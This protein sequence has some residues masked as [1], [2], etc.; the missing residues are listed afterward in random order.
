[1]PRFPSSA[2]SGGTLPTEVN[3]LIASTLPKIAP[4]IADNVFNATPFLWFMRQKGRVK[5]WDGGESIE[6]P[7][8]YDKN[9]YARAYTNYEVMD[10]GPPQGIG[11]SVWSMAHYRVPIMYSRNSAA[12]N[13]G[14]AQVL[15]L[16]QSLRQQAELSLVDAINTDFTDE[17]S[18]QD[19]TKINSI[20]FVVEANAKGSQSFAPGGIS[21]STYSWWRNQYRVLSSTNQGILKNLRQIYVDCANGNDTPDLAVCDDMTYVN[22]ETKIAENQRFVN[23]DAARVGFENFTYK[24]MTIFYDKALPNDDGDGSGDGSM[25]LVNT[26]YLKLYIGTDA[27]FRV[28]QPEY[29]RWQDAYVGVIL[30]DIQL[31]CNNCKRQGCLEGGAYYTDC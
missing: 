24:G 10:A 17:I 16:I 31:V 12:A 3:A 23:E 28:V 1:M 22:L 11:T 13:S 6:E 9:P 26:K 7:I 2:I 14:Q 25:F 5:P 8:M 19:S 15:S 27:N 20:F 30:V 21:K 4:A 18:S 29:D